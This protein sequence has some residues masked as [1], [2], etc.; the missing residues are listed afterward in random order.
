MIRVTGERLSQH[1]IDI[2]SRVAMQI[3]WQRT[4]QSWLL[5]V[6]ATTRDI[7]D[8][9][10]MMSQKCQQ[11]VKF[12]TPEAKRD[13]KHSG[14]FSDSKRVFNNENYEII[15]NPHLSFFFFDFLEAL[16]ER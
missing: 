6:D 11:R 3:P 2:R 8:D 4:K 14:I 15:N 7:A 13:G 1:D 9:Y 12:T 16:V 10:A 5:C